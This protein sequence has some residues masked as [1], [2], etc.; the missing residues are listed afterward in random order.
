MKRARVFVVYVDDKFA[1]EIKRQAGGW[2]AIVSTCP[3]SANGTALGLFSST[4]KAELAIM[5]EL[6]R[7]KTAVTT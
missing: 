3:D 6:E 1:G 7:P 5:R 2:Q 4:F